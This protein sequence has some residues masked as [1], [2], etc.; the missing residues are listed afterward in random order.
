MPYEDLARLYNRLDALGSVDPRSGAVTINRGSVEAALRAL[1]PPDAV[2]DI[3][4]SLNAIAAD[5]YAMRSGNGVPWV[6]LEHMLNTGVELPSSVQDLLGERI[7]AVPP[8]EARAL[9]KERFGQLPQFLQNDDVLLRVGPSR[10]DYITPLPSPQESEWIKLNE[11][12]FLTS[13]AQQ[14]TILDEAV[15]CLKNGRYRA[16]WWGWSLCWDVPCTELIADFFVKSSVGVGV[17]ALLAAALAA[18]AAVALALIILS[19]WMHLGLGVLL[20]DIVSP[21]GACLNGN[22]P[23][24]WF[25]AFIWPSPA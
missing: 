7:R 3:R 1:A 14:R 17:A 19:F 24:P 13:E 16:H 4:R 6:T 22:W 10:S 12:V 25:G 18:P 20:R 11:V 2:E 23:T 9:L 8:D 5:G 21:R 15:W